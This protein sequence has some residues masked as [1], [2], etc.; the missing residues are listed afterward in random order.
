[1]CPRRWPAHRHR[2]PPPV[3]PPMRDRSVVES[4]AVHTAR[5][6]PPDGAGAPGSTSNRFAPTLGRAVKDVN[7]V[8]GT[9]PAAGRSAAPGNGPSWRR[10]SAGGLANP[11][12][13]PSQTNIFD[14]LT[15]WMRIA[16]TCPQRKLNEQNT[17]RLTFQTCPCGR[18]PPPKIVQPKHMHALVLLALTSVITLS[19]SLP[20]KLASAPA[21]TRPSGY[22]AN[23]TWYI[24]CHRVC[25]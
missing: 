1:M 24:A 21:T 3:S 9:L 6:R 25:R 5:N 22:P 12:C 18:H 15:C 11:R 14:A 13:R 19:W 20:T 8:S 7:A 16:N 2:F 17:W 23:D 4:S 10:G